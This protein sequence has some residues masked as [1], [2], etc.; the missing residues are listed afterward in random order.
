M[1]IH[2]S[3]LPPQY[4]ERKVHPRTKENIEKWTKLNPFLITEI[5]TNQDCLVFL[6]EFS[7]KY[8]LDVLK[9]FSFEPQGQYKS[10]IWRLCVLYEYGGIYADIDQEPLFAISEFLDLEKYDIC[11]CSNMG[12]HNISNGF[13]FSKGK[14]E[15][16]KNSIMELLRRYENSEVIGGTHSMGEV[17]T[18]MT[19]GKPFEMPLGEI[20]IGNEKCLFLHEIGDRNMKYENQEYYNSFGVYSHNDTKR[21]MNSRYKTYFSDKHNHNEFIKI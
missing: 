19:K 4:I 7:K 20:T 6:E 1:K 2:H 21:V 16:L 12:L 15:I 10:D 5:W 8:S 13:I 17:V 11:L 18:Q 14:S 3:I 9:W